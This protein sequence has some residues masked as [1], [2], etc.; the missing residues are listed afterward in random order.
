MDYGSIAL[1]LTVGFFALFFLTKILGKT[2]IS[3]ITTFDFISA[4]LLGEIVGSAV[5]EKKTTV[6]QILFALSIWGVLVLL[7][8]YISQKFKR[9]RGFIEGQPTIVIHKGKIDRNMLKRSKLDIN[10]LQHLLRAKGTFSIRQVEYA[11]LE[12][13]GSLSVLNKA[14]FDPPSRQDHKMP[15]QPV[16][17]P[18]TMV[19]DGEII[20]DNLMESGFDEV[21]LQNQISSFGTTNVKDIMY[22]EWLEGE[23]LFIQTY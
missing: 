14:K 5:F 18:V 9:T 12:T 7:L 3:Q 19:S 13:D 8:E 4:L 20:Y 10:Q 1:E 11:I 6:W 22:A 2:Q 21:W 23:G 17:L 16:F 15:E